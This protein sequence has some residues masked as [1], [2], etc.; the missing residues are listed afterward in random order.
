MIKKYRPLLWRHLQRIEPPLSS[1][2]SFLYSG[3][4]R[5]SRIDIFRSVEETPR[6]A[7]E[8]V[9]FDRGA[10][11]PMNANQ[12]RRR[13]LIKSAPARIFVCVLFVA[14]HTGCQILSFKIKSI[15]QDCIEQMAQRLE[16][17]NR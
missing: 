9:R 1:M 4:A 14:V 3:E 2:L 16:K 15:P 7:L 12:K 13:F 17:L 8:D 10:V 11:H 6:L 5:G